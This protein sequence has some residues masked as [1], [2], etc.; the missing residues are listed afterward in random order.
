MFQTFLRFLKISKALT[1]F[2]GM[3][4]YTTNSSNCD[5]FYRFIDLNL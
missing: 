3:V 2:F 4:L 1:R 5:S